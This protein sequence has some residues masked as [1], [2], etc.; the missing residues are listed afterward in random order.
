MP[1]ERARFRDDRR[2]APGKGLCRD[3]VERRF[4]HHDHQHMQCQRKRRQEV[5]RHTGA[6]QEAQ[7][8]KSRIRRMRMRMHDAAA[9]HHRHHQEQISV[10]GYYFRDPQH[11]QI[12]GT[13]R[14]SVLREEKDRGDFR[15][16]RS[17]RR[18]TAC[19]EALQAQIIREHHVR[20]QQFLHV[21]HRA[22]HE[23]QREEQEAGR[24]RKR[25]N[26]TCRRRSKGS[27]PAG[28]ERQLIQRRRGKRQRVRFCRSHIYDKRYRRTR[29]YQIHDLAS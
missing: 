3:D 12:P 14:K 22:V 20:L 9:A 29:A 7:G 10:G 11:T 21:L 27:H 18:G 4:G 5:F 6:A 13:A 19:E 2:Y 15:G 8:E 1:D 26:G 16:Q 17:D 24:Y 28:A 25:D 23:R